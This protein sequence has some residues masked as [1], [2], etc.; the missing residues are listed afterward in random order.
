MA[1]DYKRSKHIVS[2][3]KHIQIRHCW[4]RYIS[5]VKVINISKLVDGIDIDSTKYNPEEVFI[6]SNLSEINEQSINS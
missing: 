1:V 4:L 3:N 2:K 6:G 5:N